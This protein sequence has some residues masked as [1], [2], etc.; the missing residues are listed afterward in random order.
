MSVHCFRH[1]LVN[2]T[3]FAIG[4]VQWRQYFT[5]RCHKWVV[6]WQGAKKL[7]RASHPLHFP[8]LP[9]LPAEQLI[10]FGSVGRLHVA[11]IPFELLTNTERNGTQK[12]RFG[13]RTRIAEVAR[14]R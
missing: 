6:L 12:Y 14:R 4:A 13:K 1:I 7:S 9:I 2:L 10:R 3:K 11:D 5:A 8:T